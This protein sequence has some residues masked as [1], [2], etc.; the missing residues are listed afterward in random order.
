MLQAERVLRSAR[1]DYTL[2]EV[3]EEVASGVAMAEALGV[4]PA[5]V[6][7]TLVVAVV[8]GDRERKALVLQPSDQTN[9]IALFI[10][11]RI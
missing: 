11:H 9:A 8:R 2:H 6:L 10:T 4:D 7:R 5:A 3:G 1:V